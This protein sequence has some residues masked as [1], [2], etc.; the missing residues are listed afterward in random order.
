MAEGYSKINTTAL[1]TYLKGRSGIQLRTPYIKENT[2]IAQKPSYVLAQVENTGGTASVI[3][4]NETAIPAQGNFSGTTV[5]TPAALNGKF[6][7]FSRGIGYANGSEA[8]IWDGAEMRCASLIRCTSVTGLVPAAPQD[9]TLAV[10]NELYDANNTC[11]VT[12]GTHVLLIG[13]TD[14]KSVV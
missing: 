5:Y 4:A 2:I 1:T 14:R 7:N 12:G 13:S 8:C 3:L 10:N 9:F 11:G 6:A